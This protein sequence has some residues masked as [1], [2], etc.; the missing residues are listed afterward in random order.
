MSVLGDSDNPLSHLSFLPS[1]PCYLCTAPLMATP[2]VLPLPT[3]LLTGE[4]MM[5][6]AAR[7]KMTGPVTVNPKLKLPNHAIY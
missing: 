4:G 2:L 3:V 1:Q 7:L 6:S 5:Y